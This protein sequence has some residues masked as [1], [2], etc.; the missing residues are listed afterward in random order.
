MAPGETVGERPEATS[1]L[2]VV[3]AVVTRG[4]LVLACRRRADR[5]AGGKWEFPGG[6]VESGED[7][8]SALRREIAEELGVDILVGDLFT[9][10]DTL[11]GD[12]VIR[13]VCHRAQLLGSPP[14][15]ST[16]HDQLEWVPTSDLHRLDWAAPDL[17]A[18]RL[19]TATSQRA[20]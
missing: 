2:R 5:A 15:K 17:P 1:P 19:L 12:R 6:K 10:D 13:L 18:I 20:N 9:V 4:G 8:A 16:D 7:D 3:A 11:V 14:T